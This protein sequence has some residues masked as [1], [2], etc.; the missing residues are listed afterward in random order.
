MADINFVSGLAGDSEQNTVFA[1]FP[2][3]VMVY[4]LSQKIPRWH[5]LA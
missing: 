5:K 1:P 3:R 4:Y 2:Y